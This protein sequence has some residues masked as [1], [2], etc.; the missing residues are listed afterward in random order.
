MHKV[1]NTKLM[2]KT[3]SWIGK[4]TSFPV[5]KPYVFAQSSNGHSV[6]S[7]V[8]PHDHQCHSGGYNEVFIFEHWASFGPRH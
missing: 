6:D 5:L 4:V 2:Q 1:D 7:E 8:E 3:L